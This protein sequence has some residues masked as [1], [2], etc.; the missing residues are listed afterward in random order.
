MMNEKYIA[1]NQLG[2]RPNDAKLAVIQGKQSKYRLVAIDSDEVIWEGESSAEQYDEASGVTVCKLDFSHVTREGRYRIVGEEGSS[3]PFSISSHVY[4]DVQ[5]A[6]LKAFYYLRCGE[7]LTSEYAGPWAHAAC[8]HSLVHV[9]GQPELTFDGTGGWH[10][11]GDYG[12]YIVAA[13]KAIADLLLAYELYPQTFKRKVPLPESNDVMDDLLHEVKVE[14][15]WMLKMQDAA[16]GGVYHKLTTLQFPPLDMMPEDDTADLYAMPISATATASFAASMAMAARAYAAYDEHYAE[17]CLLA[18]ERAWQWLEEHPDVEGFRNPS[19]VGTGEYGDSQDE[20]ERYWAAAE[21][22]RATGND[23]YHAAFLRYAKR[24]SFNKTSL[25]WA[26][27]GGYGTMSYLLCEH[28]REEAIVSELKQALS[29]HADQLA[30]VSSKD[31]YSISM[32]P[33]QYRWGSNMD[34][35][36]HAMLMLFAQHVEGHQRY[37]GV[38]AAHVHYLLGMNVN[39]ISYISGYGHSAMTHPHHRPS[40]GDGVDAPVPGM[41]SG[42]PNKNLQ[43]E[44]AAKHLQNRAPAACYADHEDSYAT[45]EVTIYWNSPALFVLSHFTS[46]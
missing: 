16:T 35:M 28:K 6:V 37:E 8:H 22:Y 44:Y 7:E 17:R 25:G 31:G 13:G 27:M 1:I 45:N 42:G 15:D 24:S 3:W 2:Y 19:D 23:K 26:D 12:K 30:D 39:G 9:H 46:L 40:V 38:I 21:L 11:A 18:A 20:D 34:V 32:L 29:S 10:D 43:D 14:L 41:V 4:E 33:E 36:N 5:V